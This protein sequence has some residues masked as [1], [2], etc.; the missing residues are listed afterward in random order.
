MRPPFPKARVTWSIFRRSGRRF[1]AENAARS[2]NPGHVPK[3]LDRNMLRYDAF[4]VDE[5]TSLGDYKIAPTKCV[6]EGLPIREDELF[7]AVAPTISR[8]EDGGW[9]ACH[10][11]NIPR[12]MI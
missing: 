11:I 1:G 5:W 7:I 8:G 2:K 6:T 12:C 3:H 10:F 4:T 9:D